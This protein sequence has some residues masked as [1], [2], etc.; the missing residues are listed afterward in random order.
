MQAPPDAALSAETL[1]AL[2]RALE[3]KGPGYVPHARHQDVGGRPRFTNRLILETSPYLLQ[4]A[5]NPVSWWAW[6][7]EAFAEAARLGRPV[8]LSVGYA[9]CHWCHVMERE[10]F[11]DLEIA[12]FMNAHYVCIK[13][14]REERPDVDAIYMAA[15]LKLHGHGGWPM[16]VWMDPAQR[17]FF[18]GTYF[19][20]RD[21]DRGP[22]SGFLTL[23]R[24]L[25]RLWVQD[26]ARVQGAAASLSEAVRGELSGE[27][28][29]GT[30]LPSGRLADATINAFVRALDPVHGGMRGA[31]KF[32]STMPV[33]LLLRHHARTGDA[34][35]LDAVTRSLEKMAA[36]GIYDQLGGGFHRYAVDERWLVPHFEKMLYDNALLAVAYCEAHQVTGRGD[37]AR[38]ARETLT[39]LQREMQ[40]PDGAFYAAT[41][42]DSEGHEGKFFVWRAEEIR[43]VLGADAQAFMAHYG[44][45]EQGNFEGQNI[46]NVPSPSEEAWAALAPSRAKLYAVRSARV[47]PLRDEKI[48]AAWNGLAIS[49]FAVGGR[50]LHEPGFVAQAARAASFVLERMR[51]QGRLRRSYKDDRARHD[52]TLSD[53]AFV[54]AGLLDLYEA[55]FEARWLGEALALAQEVEQHFADPNGGWFATRDDAEALLVRQKPGQDGAEPSGASV[56]V[57]NALRLAELTQDPRWRQVAER[58]LMSAAPALADRPLAHTELL[59]ALDF[60]RSRVKEV[61]LVWPA[62][63]PLPEAWAEV[64]SETFVPARV[65]VGAAEPDVLA[66]AEQLPLLEGRVAKDGGVTA[67]VCVDRTCGLPATS[68]DALRAQLG[69]ERG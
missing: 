28:H 41:D 6:G 62:G 39:Y 47:P 36:G 12:A 61:V 69:R 66:L 34:A 15:V 37:F 56:Q 68:P 8:L 5:H 25:H 59:L 50:V 60:A 19:P 10:S 45:T 14:D 65:L 55:T 24:E 11:E 21:G 3:A 2:A 22:G 46:L 16:T 29:A 9:T 23:L 40:H 32:P 48:L 27:D 52:A 33:R 44:V 43:S 63:G 7:P 57:L 51:V 17:P 4:H 20:A 49:A 53:H 31:P 1:Q 35:V 26:P 18:A 42:A 54:T 67:Y 30:A 13:V 38:V 64:L 58:A